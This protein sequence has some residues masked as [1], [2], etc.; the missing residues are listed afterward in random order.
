MNWKTALLNTINMY[1]QLRSFSL[2]SHFVVFI[3]R[4]L[5]FIFIF[6]WYKFSD[7]IINSAAKKIGKTISSLISLKS[8]SF[9]F[10]HDILF[11][12]VLCKVY[13]YTHLLGSNWKLLRQF[14]HSLSLSLTSSTF[15]SDR[16][17]LIKRRLRKFSI[18]NDWDVRAHECVW[19]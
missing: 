14:Q 1:S 18:C 3:W 11:S 9:L 6:S 5:L 15:S 17:H 7:G 16:D 12:F 19:Q 2:E 4:M 13:I 10:F 8:S